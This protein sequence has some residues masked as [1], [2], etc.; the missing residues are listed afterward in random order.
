MS[1]DNNAAPAALVRLQDQPPAVLAA[2]VLDEI[3]PFPGPIV[4]ILVEGDERREAIAHAKAHGGFLAITN[5]TS[6]K[7]SAVMAEADKVEAEI[8]GEE[9]NDERSPVVL[10]DLSPV[11][12]LGRI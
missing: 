6:S 4:P 2:V 1:D 12:V 11:G 10:R 3:V 7:A 5:R 8:R 9:T